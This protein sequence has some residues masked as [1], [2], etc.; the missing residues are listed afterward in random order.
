MKMIFSLRFMIYVEL[1]IISCYFCTIQ[2]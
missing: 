1:G 2:F